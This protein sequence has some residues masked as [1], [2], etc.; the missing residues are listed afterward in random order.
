MVVKNKAE[1]PD[2]YHT[3]NIKAGVKLVTV[4][5]RRE[6][7]QADKPSVRDLFAIWKIRSKF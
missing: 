7:Q 4:I 1:T 6:V 2:F 5:V 3:V